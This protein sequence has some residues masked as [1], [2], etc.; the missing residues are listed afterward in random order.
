MQRT[1]R[2]RFLKEEELSRAK[3]ID[4]YGPPPAKKPISA[5][6]KVCLFLF[7][8]TNTFVHLAAAD[9]ENLNKVAL[10]V[11]LTLAITFNLIKARAYLISPVIT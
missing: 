11:T 2:G 5:P 6:I 1:C 9:R 7:T 8:H 10:N 3:L 4:R